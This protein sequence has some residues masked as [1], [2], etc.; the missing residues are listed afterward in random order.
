[1]SMTYRVLVVDD[2]EMIR[3]LVKDTLS[4][5]EMEVSAASGGRQAL[6]MMART[7]YDVLL[8]DLTMPGMSGLQLLAES[9]RRH[10]DTIPIVFTGYATLKT[11]RQ[12]I[13]EGAYDYILKPFDLDELHESVS[14]ALERR[15]LVQENA[16]LRELSGL[17][18][19][20][21]AIGSAV[22]RDE[23][24]RLILRFALVQT[25]A[26]RGSVMLL[27][28]SGSKLDIVAAV[29][30][31]EHVINGTSI[32]V[33]Q[34]IAGHVIQNGQPLLVG[35]IDEDEHL[36][37]LSRKYD[38]KSFIS[39]PLTNPP[40]EETLASTEI[41]T[42][43]G[44]ASLPVRTP[45]LTSQVGSGARDVIGVLNVHRKPDGAPFTP[46]DMKLLK[47]LANHA[48]ICIENSQL[49]TD[50]ES[51][52]CNAFS[53]M[54]RLLEAKDPYTQGHTQRVTELCQRLGVELIKDPEQLNALVMAA[55]LHDIGKIGVHE[56]I[57]NKTGKLTQEEWMIVRQHPLIADRVLAPVQFLKAARPI[58]RGHHE[59]MD[60]KGY[61]DGL[62]G[63]QLTLAH[64]IIIVADAFDAM[65]STRAYRPALE[66]DRIE[67]ELRSHSGSQFDP[68]V[69]DLMIQIMHAET[70]TTA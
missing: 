15:G 54:S 24:L 1:M 3:A 48:A 52:Y 38:T 64:R 8:T 30:L 37:D 45:R 44:S 67:Q 46:S 18:E 59:R 56:S 40:A 27:D 7:D 16:R 25:G 36:R 20:S 62:R 42:E 53:S 10:P 21:E 55:R 29:G 70:L 69:A 51:T 22:G 57:L 50:L 19:V 34:G 28:D 33:G 31:P 39:V 14:R 35:N 12:A 60:G 47:I 26:T 23:L 58:V 11:A 68:D 13:R 32:D 2:E 6:D 17:F 9:L 49:V 65:S 66:P 43:D 61:P 41:I 4:A 63:E 5:T